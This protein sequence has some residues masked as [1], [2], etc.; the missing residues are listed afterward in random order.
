MALSINNLPTFQQYQSDAAT[1]AK[2]DAFFS[3]INSPTNLQ[4]E[5]QYQNPFNNLNN[6]VD[7]AN[8]S[9]VLSGGANTGS[10][11]SS[12][13]D[14]AVKNGFVNGSINPDKNY[15]PDNTSVQKAFG[16]GTTNVPSWVGNTQAFTPNPGQAQYGTTSSIQP[17]APQAM[18]F[19]TYGN[20][21]QP[22]TPP[23]TQ[24]QST[25]NS[26]LAPAAGAPGTMASNNTYTIQRGDTLSALAKRFGTDLQTLMSLNPHIH[27]GQAL[28]DPNKIYTGDTLNYGGV[29]KGSVG[30]TADV[31]GG[32][33]GMGS[34]GGLP[35]ATG[36]APGSMDGTSTTNA[37]ITPTDPILSRIE[38]MLT[39]SQDAKTKLADLISSRNAVDTQIEASPDQ[40]ANNVKGYSV[41]ANQLAGMTGKQVKTLTSLLNGYT[42]QIEDVSPLAN[43]GSI[44]DL[45]NYYKATQSQN[46][47]IS[48]NGQLVQKQADGTYKSVY[49]SSTTSDK[50]SPAYIE[51]QDAVNSGWKG[52]GDQSTWFIQ[53]QNEDANRKRSVS[54]TNN[55]IGNSGMNAKEEAVFQHIV[56]QYNK[57]PLIQAA[58]QTPVLKSS[59]DAARAKPADGSTQ[60][61]LAYSY[62]KALDTYKSGVKEGELGLV[63]S[64]DSKAGQLQNW[65]EQ[66][67][68]GQIVRP[69]I[70][71]QI[72]DAADE[73]YKTISKAA[74]AKAK[75]YESNANTSGVGDAWK[76]YT[77][78]FTPSYDN[79]SSGFSV[80]T[81]DGQTH[82][83]KDQASLDAFKKAAHL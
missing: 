35:G 62:V 83:F 15:F 13:I 29:A 42:R 60:L 50:H 17:M 6:A 67:Q 43:Q 19:P 20:N 39:Q 10:I 5:Y 23:T 46:D 9:Q 70:V 7:R 14:A 8:Q 79:Q 1:K 4:Y 48:I 55:I 58:D 45:L 3:S 77:S 30:S 69:E 54:V 74:A 49:D 31:S 26:T 22:P 12:I 71:K 36:N 56:D 53:Y 73:L 32:I 28:S 65:A 78:Q 11:N 59:I 24:N 25:V 44:S 64:V 75:S 47:P 57:S 76:S 41:N 61:N 66:M 80:Q 38:A 33:G 37:P 52:T 72:A 27:N 34:V 40:I 18:S 68:S 2:V 21:N 16:G 51:F 81:P 82:T 63:Q